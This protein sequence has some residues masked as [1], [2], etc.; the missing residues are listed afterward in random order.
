MRYDRLITLQRNTVTRTV[1]GSVNREWTTYA[2]DVPARFMNIG[3]GLAD[4]SNERVSRRV[5]QFAIR[6]SWSWN[7][8]ENDQVI[9]EGQTGLITSIDEN[10]KLP[11]RTEWIIE[12]IFKDNN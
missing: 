7:L 6:Y 3:G 2:S 9:F 8:Q 12:V 4:E 5:S 1:S 11:R 10:T